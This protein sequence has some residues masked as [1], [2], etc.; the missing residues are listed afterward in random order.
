MPEVSRFFGIVISMFYK[1]HSPPHYHARYAGQR[2][3][4][5]LETLEVIQVTCPIDRWRS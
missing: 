2:A 1:D 3:I 4:V 5:S